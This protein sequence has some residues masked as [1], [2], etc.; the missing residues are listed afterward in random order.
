M[1]LSN[2]QLSNTVC[3]HI[4]TRVAKLLLI[5]IVI[6]IVMTD[7]WSNSNSNSNRLLKIPE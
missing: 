1:Q 4:C 2:M 5:V 7:L 6:V 3:I